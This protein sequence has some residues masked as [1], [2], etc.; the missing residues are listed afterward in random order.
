MEVPRLVYG[1]PISFE[2]DMILHVMYMDHYTTTTSRAHIVNPG[3][4]KKK[5]TYYKN[6]SQAALQNF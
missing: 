5:T 4:H 2:R 6:L 1:T 3:T